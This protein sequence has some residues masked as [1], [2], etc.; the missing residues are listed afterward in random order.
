M[1]IGTLA[2]ILCLAALAAAAGGCAVADTGAFVRLQ[3]EMDGLKKE[4][5]AVR[6]SAASPPSY[7]GRA[8]TGDLSAV[9]RHVAD[10]AAAQ[11]QVKSDLLAAS[12]RADET[13]VQM[14]KEISR[15]NDKSAEQG[16][17]LQEIRGRLAKVEEIDRR[18]AVLEEKMGRLAAGSLSSSAAPAPAPQDWKSPEEM[19]DY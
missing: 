3:E 11:D 1:R 9:Q 13:K 10:L 18:V 6:G 15:L 12:T 7:P 8:E 4:V 5:A 2:S 16:H 14:Q 17:A 19:Y